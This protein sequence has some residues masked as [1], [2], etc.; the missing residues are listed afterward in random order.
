MNSLRQAWLG[1]HMYSQ[2]FQ[3]TALGPF[4]SGAGDPP[5][6]VEGGWDGADGANRRI[7]TN[8]PTWTYV[9][10]FETDR[11]YPDLPFIGPSEPADY[12]W[13]TNH[14]APLR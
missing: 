1:W 8:S 11:P 7:L 9:T 10:S 5:L 12:Q 13:M 6:W 2:D 4:R 14:I 3:D